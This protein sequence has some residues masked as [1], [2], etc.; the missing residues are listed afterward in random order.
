MIDITKELKKD[1]SKF[2]RK[3]GVEALRRV[4]LGSPVDTGLY[5][6]SHVVFNYGQAGNQGN[7]DKNGSRTLGEG[8]KKLGEAF[9]IENPFNKV[10]MGNNVKYA[11][12]IEARYGVYSAMFN[13]LSILLK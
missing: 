12:Y 7:I 3:L 4:I 9:P 5:R 2:V 6:G 1:L 8:T 13:D 10:I 11:Q